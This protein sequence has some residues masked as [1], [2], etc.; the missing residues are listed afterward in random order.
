LR[1]AGRLR[2]RGDHAPV[3]GIAARDVGQ[4]L[5]VTAPPQRLGP[6]V[7]RQLSRPAEHHATGLSSLAA[8][9]GALIAK[10]MRVSVGV[11]HNMVVE[12]RD[13]RR[14]VGLGRPLARSEWRTVSRVPA[15][16]L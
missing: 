9:A 6:L 1:E 11:V 8:V 15:A 4:G 13:L 14:C 2:Q 16:R 5:A 7:R 12:A 10:E 3:D